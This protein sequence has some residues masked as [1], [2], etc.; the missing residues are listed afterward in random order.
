MDY[1]NPIIGSS[2][3][4]IVSSPVMSTPVTGNGYQVSTRGQSMDS[5]VVTTPLPGEVFVA[6]GF[7]KRSVQR[8][9]GRQGTLELQ[10]TTGAVAFEVAATGSITAVAG[11][12][13]IDGETFTLDDGVNTPTVFEFDS[14]A[15]AT[16]VV[17]T[18]TGGDSAAT[19][20]AAII[21]AINGVGAGLAITASS[22]TGAVVILTNGAVGTVGNELIT[23][24]VVNAGFVI[25]GMSGGVNAG[26]SHT[27]AYITDS[28]TDLT[29]YIV[30]RLDAYNRPL[31]QF[32]NA[33]TLKAAVTPTYT[34]VGANQSLTI[35]LRWDTQNVI[36]ASTGRYVTLRVN[37]DQVPGANW[38]TNPTSS[39]TKFQP[40]YVVL[41]DLLAGGASGETDFN[42]IIEMVQAS[43]TVTSTV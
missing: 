31:V 15:T 24:T 26:P 21:A 20:K 34:A 23:K 14:N 37:Q 29:N 8:L 2:G 4:G 7:G 22:G 41:G 30:I 28:L 33:G 6:R 40:T 3:S 16:G 18:F 1:P 38:S 9:T 43:N 27:V 10:I 36:E 13:L 35:R 32:S 42:G 12:A 19:V 17:V 5:N 11:S 39:W 25:A